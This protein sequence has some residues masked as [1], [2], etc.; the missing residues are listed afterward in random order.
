MNPAVST[1]MAWDVG[2]SIHLS[3]PI[4][5]GTSSA[6]LEATAPIWGVWKSVPKTAIVKTATVCRD[7]ACVGPTEPTPVEMPGTC[8]RNADCDD[9]GLVCRDGM[10]VMDDRSCG[11]AGCSCADTGMCSEGFTCIADECRPDEDVCRFNTECG[12][13]RV[14]IDGRCAAECTENADC[15]TGQMCESGVCR[16]IPPNVG[17]CDADNPCD[18]GFTCVDAVCRESCSADSE[19]GEGRYC[20]AGTCRVDDRASPFCTDDSE[21]RFAC[22]NGLCRTPCE[23][24]M[25]CSRVD[26]QFNFC[27]ENY[28]ATTNEATSD[29]AT[30][31][32]CSGSRECVDGICR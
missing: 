20:D 28:C 3:A 25:E 16:D 2:R 10:C 5:G 14:C 31:S 12:E 32:D 30:S 11:D 21:C 18:D 29:C 7:G 22:I 26:V 9:D 23:T 1:V 19:C 8:V 15:P 17:E 6:R 13:S 24:S 4:A 27:L